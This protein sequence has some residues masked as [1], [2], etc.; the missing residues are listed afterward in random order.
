M[1][2][3]DAPWPVW[4]GLPLLGAWLSADDTS[5]GQTWF[6]QPLPAAILTGVL[7][8]DPGAA[9]LPGLLLQLVVMGNMPVGASFRLDEAGATV[10]VVGGA[11]LAGWTLP[12]SPI[13]L[14]VWTE[15]AAADLGW[16]VVLTVVASL[17]GGWVVHG[18]R[19]RRLGWMLDGYRSVRDGD[20]GRLE[21]LHRRCL[22]ATLA[23]GAVLTLC[24]ILVSAWLWNIG[25]PA[26]LA[27]PLRAALGLVPLMIPLLAVGSVSER[28]GPRRAWPLVTAG[29]AVG[30][31]V[32]WLAV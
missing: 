31:V 18:E 2:P 22:L 5:L 17:A 26:S 20:L 32:A 8:G 9:L 6:S 3:F 23:R 11:M 12:G 19:Q 24:W 29:A 21:G 13:S 30:F 7:L 27:G 10:G 1:T 25:R 16:L 14:T 15:P 4:V 28:F